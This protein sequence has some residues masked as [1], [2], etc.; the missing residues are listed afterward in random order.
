MEGVD[1]AKERTVVKT[2][3]NSFLENMLP[4]RYW[5]FDASRGTQPAFVF[6]SDKKFCIKVI[7]DID[8]TSNNQ[9]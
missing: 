9:E 3:H 2:D 5:C 1:V 4:V 8:H 7:D 6:Y